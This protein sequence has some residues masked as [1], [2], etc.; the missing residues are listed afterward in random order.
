MSTSPQSGFTQLADRLRPYLDDDRLLTQALTHRSYCAEH[1]GSLSNER[2][3]FLG[4]AVL[5]LVITSELYRRLPD[6]PEGDLARI[7]AEVVSSVALAPLAHELGIGDA[8]LLGRGEEHSG[9]RMKPSLLADTLEAVFGAIYLASG[10]ELTSSFVLGITEGTLVRESSRT[11]FG[12]AKNRLQELAARRG[13]A[14]PV[15]EITEQGPD[16]KKHFVA[17]VEVAGTTGSGE[18]NSKKEAERQAAG[19]VIAALEDQG[20]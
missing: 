13:V 14:N 4:D 2:L 3:E 7:R 17:S 11:T 12:D 15:Y 10:V 20:A 9:G 8:L 5:G 18:G 19:A 6:L 16:H 1:D